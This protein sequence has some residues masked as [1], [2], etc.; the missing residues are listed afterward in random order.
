MRV[1]VYGTQDVDFVTPDNKVIKGKSVY[2]GFENRYVTGLK[3]NKFFISDS[4]E[5]INDIVPDAEIEISFDMNGKIDSV[6]VY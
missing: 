1:I 2:G 5:C 4:I 3:T 6:S